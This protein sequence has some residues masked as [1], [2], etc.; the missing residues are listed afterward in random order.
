MRIA[1][2]ECSV[3]DRNVRL[4]FRLSRGSFATAV[5]HELI[6]NAF[7]QSVEAEE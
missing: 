6:A 5:L 4:R 2:P 1:Q 7:E 3:E